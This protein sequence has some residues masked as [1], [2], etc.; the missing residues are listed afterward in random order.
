[1][2]ETETTEAFLRRIAQYYI[3][4]GSIVCSGPDA[5]RLLSLARR[6]DAIPDESEA[7]ALGRKFLEMLYDG[8][9][10]DGPCIAFHALEGEKEGTH[11]RI[12]AFGLGV[13]IL[14][15]L[16]ALKESSNAE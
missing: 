4:T 7:A 14:N 5:S 13:T 1:M 12:T 3:E 10:T 6:G 16:T 8:I 2:S 11:G 15:T 9:V